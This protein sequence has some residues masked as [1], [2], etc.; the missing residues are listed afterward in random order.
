MS[1]EGTCP[2]CQEE[3]NDPILLKSCKVSYCHD[4]MG[5]RYLTTVCIVCTGSSVNVV[6]VKVLIVDKY[7]TLF[8][9]VVN[10]IFFIYGC[11]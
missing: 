7:P 3:M 8:I 1:V 10:F 9:L 11:L 6:L 4:E 2:I 5:S